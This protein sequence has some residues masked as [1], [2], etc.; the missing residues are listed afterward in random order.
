MS[1]PQEIDE[2]VT[3]LIGA[4]FGK[5]ALISSSEYLRPQVRAASRRRYFTHVLGV[6]GHEMRFFSKTAPTSFS[7]LVE[8]E[9]FLADRNFEMFSAPAFYGATTWSDGGLATWEAVDGRSYSMGEAPPSILNRL[10][11][12]AAELVSVTDSAVLNIPVLETRSTVFEELADKVLFILKQ[13]GKQGVEVDDLMEDARSYDRNEFRAFLRFDYLGRALSHLDFGN[14]NVIFPP[15]RGKPVVIDWGSVGLTPPGGTLRKFA[16]LGAQDRQAAAD[17]FARL[18]TKQGRKVESH[19]ILFTLC[20][21][22]GL[23][24]LDWACQRGVKHRQKTVNAIR[25]GFAHLRTAQISPWVPQV[26][27]ESFEA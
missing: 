21:G 20:A 27:P 14:S 3:R 22:Q 16:E 26:L 2:I 7:G 10:V 15:N 1:V 12:I 17:L 13:L 9:A 18:L 23:R 6:D 19:D 25:R 24:F 5:T 11:R 8:T 4:R